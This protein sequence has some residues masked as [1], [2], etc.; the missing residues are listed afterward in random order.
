MSEIRW[1][2][3]LG[4]WVIVTPDRASRPFQDEERKCP[5]CPDQ[6]ETEGEWK[7][8][9][10]DNRFAALQP[11]S[12][13]IYLD[14]PLVIGAPAHG[15]CKVIIESRNHDEQ[16]EDMN[17]NQLKNV[18]QEFLRN[19]VE[20]DSKKGIE[21]VFQFENRGKAIGVSLDHPHAQVYAMPFVPP[22]IQ[23][24]MVQFRKYKQ[25][26]GEC[27]VCETIENEFK[28]HARIIKES[29]NF[30]SIVPYGARLPYEVH[31]YPKKHVP[32]IVELEEDLEEFGIILSDVVKRY[33]KV[34][35]EI[36]YTMVFHTRPSKLKDD[37]WHFHVEFY[38]PWRDRSRLKYLAGVESGTWTY[39]NDSSPEAKAKELREAL[40][41]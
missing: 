31:V 4:E 35:D 1:N 20:L 29:D 32:S 7:V 18:Y 21:Y 11:D 30:V 16:I 5:F 26:N 6:E 33:K 15:Y 37:L 41:E 19:F 40:S 23:R 24:E 3:M 8:L 39:T 9:T 13:L 27:L 2:S 17:A 12:G 25:E 10:L 22:R 28:S 36:A 34:F 38:P 14:P